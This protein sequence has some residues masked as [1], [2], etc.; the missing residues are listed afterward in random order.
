MSKITYNCTSC[1]KPLDAEV[2]QTAVRG[3]LKWYI[4]YHCQNCD[5]VGEADD[6]GIP[7]EEIR[8][9]LIQKQGR[10]ELRVDG[11][12]ANRVIIAKVLRR[13]LGLSLAE[14]THLMKSIPSLLYC[15]TQVEAEWLAGI[16]A[17]EGI[18]AR[19]VGSVPSSGTFQ[20]ENREDQVSVDSVV[21]YPELTKGGSE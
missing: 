10:W 8:D 14:V 17:S 12:A 4:S 7:P 20:K 5:A 9:L 16:L 15:G 11:R 2:G 19:A 21:T 6:M 1:G 3:H 13:A 18:V